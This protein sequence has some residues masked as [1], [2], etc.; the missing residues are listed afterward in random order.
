MLSWAKQH[1]VMGRT[2]LVGLTFDIC[3]L[4]KEEKHD[5]CRSKNLVFLHL[6]EIQCC[7]T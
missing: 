6:L 3:V 2:W 4:K 7:A 5:P 1:E